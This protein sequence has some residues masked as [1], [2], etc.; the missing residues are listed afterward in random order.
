MNSGRTTDPSAILVCLLKYRGRWELVSGTWQREIEN[1]ITEIIDR[2]EASLQTQFVV[3]R[4]L[5]YCFKEKI[6]FD[7]QAQFARP[8][9]SCLIKP[10]GIKKN[11]DKR[12]F[13]FSS[14][15][16]F[17]DCKLQTVLK[18]FT[19]QI[20]TSLYLTHAFNKLFSFGGK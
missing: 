17:M 16:L 18:Y 8:P 12:L 11:F 10:G 7:T 14:T 5:I 2:K 3:F 4:W 1:C 19:R 6:E 15:G 9:V 13:N 20:N